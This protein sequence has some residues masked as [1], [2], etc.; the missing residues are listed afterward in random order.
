MLFQLLGVGCWMLGRSIV[1][2]KSAASSAVCKCGR[3]FASARLSPQLRSRCGTYFFPADWGGGVSLESSWRA[4]GLTPPAAED[5]ALFRPTVLFFR[6]PIN[7]EPLP[8][9]TY[10]IA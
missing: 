8:I 5:A 4:G 3:Q 7:R 6:A 10:V 1:G 2:R 9:E